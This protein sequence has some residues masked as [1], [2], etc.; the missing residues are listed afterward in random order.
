MRVR[1]AAGSGLALA[2]LVLVNGCVFGGGTPADYCAMEVSGVA[3]YRSGAGFFDAA[4]R[5]KGHA[6]SAGIV[7]LA[8]RVGS[9]RFVS[10]NGVR[11]GPGP[12]EARVQLDLTGRPLEYVAVLEVAGQ[13]CRSKIDPPGA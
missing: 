9:G 1:R 13:R 11:V 6:G 8:A 12:F 2:L 7:W 10:G 4:Y 3:E 5:V